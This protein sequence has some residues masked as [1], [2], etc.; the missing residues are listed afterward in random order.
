[1][2]VRNELKPHQDR[3]QLRGD[4]ATSPSERRRQIKH[5]VIDQT[6]TLFRTQ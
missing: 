6:E 4:L 1:M 3:L 2:E 5:D